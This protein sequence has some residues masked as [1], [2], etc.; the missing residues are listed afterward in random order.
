MH[1][2]LRSCAATEQRHGLTSSQT[3]Y[4]ARS[5]TISASLFAAIDHAVDIALVDIILYEYTTLYATYSV[6]AQ[7]LRS[8]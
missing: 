1:Q 3:F 6:L 7:H 5:I 4:Y 8:S 2:Y